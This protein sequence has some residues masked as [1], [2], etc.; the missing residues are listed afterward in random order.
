MDSSLKSWYAQK[1]PPHLCPI[2]AL[3]HTSIPHIKKVVTEG[4]IT[5]LPFELVGAAEGK[6]RPGQ[7]LEMDT[8]AHLIG[9]LWGFP[10]AQQETFKSL[11]YMN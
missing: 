4:T 5:F 11:L 7:G 8:P 1:Y 2:C 3:N 6:I 10:G 9:L